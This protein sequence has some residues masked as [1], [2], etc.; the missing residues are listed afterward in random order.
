MT[1][2]KRLINEIENI[3]GTLETVDIILVSNRVVER[4]IDG[5]TMRLSWPSQS[6]GSLFRG[7]PSVSDYRDW[8]DSSAY[9]ALL[10]DGSFIQ[11]SYDLRRAE[12]VGHRLEYFPC[13]FRLDSE[14]LAEFGIIDAVH[15]TLES[16]NIA[17]LQMTSPIRFDYDPS[18]Q[19]I[20]HP[21]SHLTTVSS[22]CRIPVY[23]P[24]SPGRFIKFILM[25]FYP[26]QWSSVQ[27]LHDIPE[28]LIKR[29]LS[30]NEERLL[31]VDI[32]ER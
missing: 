16:V 14:T 5:H 26:R 8:I 12:I 25:N 9:S 4:R 32:R 10:Y 19:R 30:Q 21:A 23:G 11:I 27:E 7:N 15:L 2:N 24:L 13:P 3:L 31:H 18:S 22:E 6:V 20:G 1:T 28:N 29:T 17:E